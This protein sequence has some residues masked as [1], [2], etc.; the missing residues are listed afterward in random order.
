MLS[1]HEGL[2]ADSV[3]HWL[4]GGWGID[5]LVGRQTRTHR[6]LD[7]AVDTDAVADAVAVL[8]TL[9]YTA[10]TDWLPVRLELAAP[11][12]RWVDLHP[13]VFDARGHGRQAGLDGSHFDYP[14]T[15]LVVGAIQGCPLPCISAARQRAFHAGYRLRPQDEADLAELDKL[16][17]PG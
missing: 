11:G 10:E 15:D 16:A 9:G 1:V 3:R 6:D 7:L 17:V 4:A 12:Q 13:V 14:A 5:A 8:G 2:R